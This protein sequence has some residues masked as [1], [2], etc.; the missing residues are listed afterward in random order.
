MSDGTRIDAHPGRSCALGTLYSIGIG[1]AH[2]GRTVKAL[3]QDLHITVIDARTGEI[4]REL[5]LDNTL[6]YQPQNSK[7]PVP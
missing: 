2:N 6:K 7:K 4:L 3:V 5:T 1:R